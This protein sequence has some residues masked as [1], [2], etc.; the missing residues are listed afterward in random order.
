M[1][2]V[3]KLGCPQKARR[4]NQNQ[5]WVRKNTSTTWGNK[6]ESSGERTNIKYISTKGKTIRTKQD[7]L[8]QQKQILS[9]A[10]RKWYE[11]VPTTK[12]KR[13]RTILDWNMATKKHNDWIDNMTRELGIEEGPKAEIHIYL[14]NTTLKTYHTGIHQTMM[15]YMV[16]SS[17]NARLFTDRL[18]L[19]MNRCLHGS[20]VSNGWPKEKPHWSKMT[21]AKKPIQTTIDP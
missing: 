14:L 5:D 7:I 6:S 17:G 16:S 8:K 1:Q 20:H 10:G 4:K 18:A 13:T 3:R 2:F 15:E 19:E 9:T 11:N 12:W 21:Q